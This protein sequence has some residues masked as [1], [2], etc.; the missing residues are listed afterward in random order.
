MLINNQNKGSVNTRPFQ[1]SQQMFMLSKHVNER[2]IGKGQGHLTY[3]EFVTLPRPL[4]YLH[5]TFSDH[6]RSSVGDKMLICIKLW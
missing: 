3:K 1:H 4:M 2:R 5:T 6:K